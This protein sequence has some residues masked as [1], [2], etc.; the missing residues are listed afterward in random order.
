MIA[1]SDEAAL[2]AL[3]PIVRDLF[4]QRRLRQR[5]PLQRV[6]KE[7]VGSPGADFAGCLRTR[8]STSCAVPKHEQQMI[9]M[10]PATPKVIDRASVEIETPKVI[11]RASVENEYYSMVCGAAAGI[12]LVTLAADFGRLL[13]LRLP[14]DATG[15][16]GIAHRRGVER[17][18]HIEEAENALDIEEAENAL[19]IENAK[20]ALDIKTRDALWL[21][22]LRAHARP[23][24]VDEDPLG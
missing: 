4:G 16:I 14:A 19:D 6:L 15:A 20:N 21:E 1:T 10:L 2:Q 9:E 17:A 7:L 23:C 12:G 3:K 5:F 11:D 18:L 13:R 8:Q 22:W 24:V